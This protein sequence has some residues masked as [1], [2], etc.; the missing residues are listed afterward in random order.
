M[1]ELI[2]SGIQPSASQVHLGNYLGAMKRFVELQEQHPLL[3]CIVDLHALTSVTKKEEL[4]ENTLSLAAAYF[5]VGLLKEST[6]VFKQSDIPEVCELS[7]YFS[8]QFPLGLL[9]RAHAFKDKKAKKEQVNAGL[10]FY[11]ILMA[12]DILLYKAEKVPVGADQKQHLEMT[13]EIAEKFNF[14]FGTDFPIPEPLIE[15]STGIIPGLDGKK[16]SKSYNNYIGLFESDKDITKKIKRIVTDSKGV[17]EKKDPESC[18]IFKL[19]S[20]F[21]SSEE[22]DDLASQYR[23][24]G[25]GYGAAKE[26]LAKVVLRELAPIR[27]RYEYYMGRPD[28]IR[29]LLSDGKKRASEIASKTIEEVR[30]SLGLR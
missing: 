13:R 2:L 5:A 1:K 16:M 25:I 12:A 3:V 26:L 29:E 23:S 27:E 19:Y 21:A 4:R 6:I 15:E 30:E 24:G 10:M 9:E 28:E 20:H 17:E 14:H 18:T 7:W 8:C 11:P 22:R